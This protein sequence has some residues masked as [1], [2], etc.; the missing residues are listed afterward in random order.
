MKTLAAPTIQNLAERWG[1][2]PQWDQYVTIVV[3]GT[4]VGSSEDGKVPVLAFQRNQRWRFE[5]PI[6]LIDPEEFEIFSALPDED[7]P[8]LE[9]S[10]GSFV[11][12]LTRYILDESLR[13]AV[14]ERDG[15]GV[16]LSIYRS[17]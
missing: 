17:K 9:A 2:P 10:V 3:G 1:L 13:V 6:W 5:F 8:T 11:L 12:L 7:L 4:L 16:G 14:G 15:P